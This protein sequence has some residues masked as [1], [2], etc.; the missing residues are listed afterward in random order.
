MQLDYTEVES[1]L[2]HKINN[3]F[4]PFL[5]LKLQVKTLKRLKLIRKT[6]KRKSKQIPAE[7][8]QVRRR[9]FGLR[10]RTIIWTE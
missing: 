6:I 8:K 1:T 2:C 7:E 4:L 10:P 3:H 5:V 9:E